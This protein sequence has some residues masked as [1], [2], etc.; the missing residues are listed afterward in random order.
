M[1]RTT[2]NNNNNNNNNNNS[3]NNNNLKYVDQ[4]ESKVNLIGMDNRCMTELV[5]S[6]YSLSI[7]FQKG[8]DIIVTSQC[9][10]NVLEQENIMNI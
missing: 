3:N 8:G 2:M 10:V 4:V 7:F 6:Y 1:K 5:N 9:H